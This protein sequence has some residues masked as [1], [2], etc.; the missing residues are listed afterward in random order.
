MWDDGWINRCRLCCGR[1]R[2]PLSIA[3]Q[4]GDLFDGEQRFGVKN[5]G[6][7]IPGHGG[8]LEVDGLQRRAL[9]WI[10]AVTGVGGRWRFPAASSRSP[11]SLI[12]R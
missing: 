12:S 4:A 5:S 9:A 10:F 8:V 11:G 2:A 7:I 6:T 1:S 3:A